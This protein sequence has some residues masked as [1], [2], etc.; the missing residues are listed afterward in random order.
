MDTNGSYINLNKINDYKANGVGAKYRCILIQ[1]MITE[2]YC[3]KCM[4]LH[5]AMKH[6]NY[7][8][9]QYILSN[10][11]HDYKLCESN[12]TVASKIAL[13]IKT[14]KEMILGIESVSLLNRMRF[15]AAEF[16]IKAFDARI[17]KFDTKPILDELNEAIDKLIADIAY[18]DYTANEITELLA[19]L[20]TVVEN[21][22]LLQG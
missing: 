3:S 12:E 13:S 4:K 15:I 1:K 16:F 21:R 22:L 14:A 17:Y 2:E 8:Y 18:G 11:K 6:L 19:E 7:Q 5:D 20:D 9:C 10:M